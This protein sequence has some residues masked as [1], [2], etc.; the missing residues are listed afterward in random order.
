MAGTPL[1]RASA[2]GVFDSKI[3]T[4]L[5]PRGIFP[6][7]T[8][9]FHPQKFS[10]YSHWQMG[11]TQAGPQA[12]ESFITTHAGVLKLATKTRNEIFPTWDN[13][14]TLSYLNWKVI[15]VSRLGKGI[16]CNLYELWEIQDKGKG[17][18]KGVGAAMEKGTQAVLILFSELCIK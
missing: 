12:W 11:Q 10:K 18:T 9:F 14:P 13:F 5:I 6:S 8:T 16:L 7:R 17:G 15:A 4:K 2:S 3:C 1:T